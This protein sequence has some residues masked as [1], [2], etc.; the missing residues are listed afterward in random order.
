[1]YRIRRA[2]PGYL[3]RASPKSVG[4]LN[5]LAS[6]G[7]LSVSKINF[8]IGF[9][10]ERRYTS[11]QQ[12]LSRT[13]LTSPLDITPPEANHIRVGCV[14]LPILL[15]VYASYKVFVATVEPFEVEISSAKVSSS[16]RKI[17]SSQSV[18]SPNIKFT[19]E[20]PLPL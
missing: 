3:A 11:V 6:L 4:Y 8:R 1:M 13:R 16:E 9:T 18:G 20:A 2:S 7:Y 14:P 10:Q 5:R 12:F 15:A 19:W 17:A